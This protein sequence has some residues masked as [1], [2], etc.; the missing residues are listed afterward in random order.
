MNKNLAL[1]LAGTLAV[2]SAC[3]PKECRNI[4]LHRAAYHSSAVD[5]NCTAQLV[6]DGIVETGQPVGY[7]VLETLADGRTSIVPKN[8]REAPFQHRRAVHNKLAGPHYE[9]SVLERGIHQQTDA[10]RLNLVLRYAEGARKGQPYAE[11]LATSDG[12]ATWQPVRCLDL[13]HL[14]PGAET[15]VSFDFA[16][17]DARNGYK[18]VLDGEGVSEWALLEWDF[19]CKGEPV[20][21]LGNE[22]FCSLWVAEDAAP[23]WLILDLGAESRLRRT[24]F[25]WV[26]RPAGG[27]IYCSR[28][29]FDWKEIAALAQEDAQSLRGRG[30]YV[31][32]EMDAAANGQPVALSEWEVFGTNDLSLPASA[33][34]LVRADQAEDPAAWIPATV[35]G[36][37]LSSFT[38]IGAVPDIRYGNDQE[39]ISDSYF[40]ADFLYRGTLPFAG[41]EGRRVYLDFG[42]INWKADV[43]LNGVALGRMDG[44]FT[45]GRFEVTDL[46]RVGDN[47]VEVRV[48]RPAHPGGAKASTLQR[49]PPNGGWLGADNPTFHASIGWDWIPTMRGRDIGI[50]RDVAFSTS[51]DV[52]VSD[53]LVQTALNLPDTTRASVT[54]EA[55]LTNH[56]PQARE[57][58]WEG[59][60]GD[61]AFE[62]PVTLQGGE[63]RSVCHTLQ[64]DHPRLWWPNGHGE[65]FLYD[66]SVSVS[67][68]GVISD[69]CAFKAGIRQLRYS[70]EGGILTA[71]VNGRRVSGRGGNWGFSELNLRYTPREYDIAVWYHKLM[72]FNMIRNWV[73]QTADE[74][75]Y[76][77]CDRYGILVWQDFWLAN[78]CDGPDPDD[79]A[80]FLENA[81]DYVRKIRRHPCVALY[82]GRNEGM[83]PASLDAALD[84]LV[85]RLHGDI[86]YIPDSA[87]G[88]VS[89][90]GPY[91]T[92]PASAFFDLWGAD[93]MHSER[94]VTNFPEYETV[95]RFIP[96][97][98]RWPMD[99]LWGIHDF[100]LENAQK[101]GAFADLVAGYLGEAEDIR[102]FCEQAQWVNY[103]GFRAVFE[104]RS[105]HRRGLLLWMSHN[106]W[107]SLVWAPYDYYFAQPAGF[108]GS[109]KACEPVHIQYN[110]HTG[111][112]EVV[113]WSAGDLDALQA[114]VVVMDCLGTV[115]SEASFDLSSKEDST[116]EGPA[117]PLG[118][119]VNLISLRLQ[120]G[121]EML[122]DNFY[123]LGQ[124]EGD[125]RALKELP[126]AKVGFRW[127]VSED[128][129][130]YVV[131]AQLENASEMPALMLHLSLVNRGAP[132]NA[133]PAPVS[134][135]TSAFSRLPDDDRIFPAD[136]SD[137]YFHL[138]P[139]QQKTVVIRVPKRYFS[140]PL[141]PGLELRGFNLL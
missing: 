35:P 106:A 85:N 89:G 28:D 25:H 1:L 93:R 46:V 127:E 98:D 141:T 11:V 33:W 107:P 30:R 29:G 40:N 124:P 108:F 72:N 105:E 32:L 51:G 94:G 99:D 10:M 69:S 74:E 27:R 19:F 120:R 136:Y 66:A 88:P 81:E 75:F 41:V 23:Q 8:R 111:R 34:Q 70:T 21:L 54:V 26:N 64:L 43:S 17:D 5:Y 132:V 102:S 135:C 122:S 38:D 44:A 13:R 78:P 15:A 109:R 90:R 138:L 113:N 130:N 112:V 49:I 68:D 123:V 45:R 4:A 73:G 50:W 7:E 140:V 3:S 61:A 63:T 100:G 48:R 9:L 79:E 24:A 131:T 80:L 137:N 126:K 119:G 87:D 84:R 62:Q 101:P 116:V 118:D 82:C 18:L 91:N 31:K 6:T 47:V 67:V 14:V 134:P 58:V 104:G 52:S 76:E 121:G 139:G 115:R 77:A 95:R 117:V 56:A 129:E 20:N 133:G 97:A 36:T 2:F 59:K 96:E 53:P 125:L 42:G 12:G 83:P 110:A 86:L 37:V 55:E 57:V 65:P 114:S 16:P 71:W 128:A 60:I 103:D 39:Y 92:L 22:H